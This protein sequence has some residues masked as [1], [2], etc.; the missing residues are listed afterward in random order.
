MLIKPTHMVHVVCQNGKEKK[1]KTNRSSRTIKTL[2][3]LTRLISGGLAVGAAASANAGEAIYDN[4][5]AASSGADQ[6]VYRGPLFVS[7]TATSNETITGLELALGNYGP[8]G[9]TGTV[10]VGLYSLSSLDSSAE[11]TLI[12]TLGTIDNSTIVIGGIHDY[13]VSLIANPAL[14]ADTRYW[15][16]LTDWSDGAITWSWSSD[17][18]GTNVAGEYWAYGGGVVNSNSVGGPYQ[19]ALAAAPVVPNLTITQLGNNVIVSWPNTG[20]CTLQQ[21]SNLA[22]SA[23]WATNGY[24]VNTNSSPRHQQHHHHAANGKFILPA[25]ISLKHVKTI[26]LS[27]ET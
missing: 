11:S 7:F 15:I 17:T 9:G 22:V 20:N 6:L 5:G 21:N 2:A 16:G 3:T 1:M 18:S 4:L 13:S 23:G 25:S 10:T 19:M 12:A 14:T 26:N 24:P 27:T 8:A